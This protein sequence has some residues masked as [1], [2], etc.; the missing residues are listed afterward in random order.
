MTCSIECRRTLKQ[1]NG[2]ETNKVRTIGAEFGTADTRHRRRLKLKVLSV[3]SD[4]KMACACC[5]ISYIEFLTIDHLEGG[6]ARHRREVGNGKL[7]NGG[8]AFYDWLKKNNFP[9]G[10]RVLCQNCNFSHGVFGYCPHD[11]HTD[12]L[13]T[14]L[15]IFNS[16]IAAAK[17]ISHAARNRS[18]MTTSG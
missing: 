7:N 14:P 6:G 15:D 3:Y 18:G 9:P 1:R 5:G 10:Y 17:R 12:L 2:I 13:T 4:G 11:K 16:N 8:G